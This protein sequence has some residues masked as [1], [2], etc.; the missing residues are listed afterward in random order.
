[1]RS[2]AADPPRLPLQPLLRS[3]SAS[4][5]RCPATPATLARA[6]RHEASTAAL[7][8]TRLSTSGRL[9]RGKPDCRKGRQELSPCIGSGTAANAS[10]VRGLPVERVGGQAG[11]SSRAASSGKTREAGEIYLAGLERG[12]HASWPHLLAGQ[13]LEQQGR[14]A[15]L[16]GHTRRRRERPG[17]DDGRPLPLPLERLAGGADGGRQRNRLLLARPGSGRPL[18]VDPRRAV[19]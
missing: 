14:F 19:L 10:D 3:A 11:W 2:E 16:G 9:G 17:G 4:P 18:S 6:P 15:A 7:R 5:Q 8:A 13:V 12:P 1:M